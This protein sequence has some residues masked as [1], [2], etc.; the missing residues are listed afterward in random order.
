MITE[1]IFL[2]IF[3]I[4]MSVNVYDDLKT[5]RTKNAYHYPMA[6]LLV[7]GA[8]F[9]G[10]LLGVSTTL[11]GLYALVFFILFSKIPIIL[12]GAGDI[13]ML[14]NLYMILNIVIPLKTVALFFVISV[15]YLNISFVYE[16]LIRLKKR[17]LKN[18][19][20]H[21]EAPSIFI[22]FALISSIYLLI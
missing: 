11:I 22:T 18:K 9:Q 1:Y 21:A 14:V 15:L 5:H 3:A 8:S 13:K 2:F 10:S 7:I 16:M 19:Q 12:F 6:A 4:Y 20:V 17:D